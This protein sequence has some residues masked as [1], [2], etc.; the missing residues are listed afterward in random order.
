MGSK[1]GRCLCGA[2]RF[3]AEGT[4]TEHHACHCGMC[5]RWTTGPFFGAYV[6]SVAFEGEDKIGRYESSA[7]AER[8][9][10]RTC[11]STLFY[12]L[13]PNKSYVMSVGAF[14]DPTGFKLAEEIF[15]DKKPSGYAFAGERPRFTEEE[16]F[17]KFAPPEK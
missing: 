12:F 13:K 11:G 3:V 4:D 10:C 9:F 16:T 7:W 14:D 1:S 15:I 5:R 6:K 2:V 8:G 17:A